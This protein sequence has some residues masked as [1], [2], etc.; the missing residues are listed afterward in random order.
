MEMCW[1][2]GFEDI[3]TIDPKMIGILDVARRVA[4]TTSN[5]LIIGESGTGKELVARGIHRLSPR[6]EEPFLAVNC[7][8]IPSE[9]LESELMGY[10]R[11]AFTGAFAR[12][13]GDFESANGGTIFL[14]EISNLPLPLQA[15]LLRILQEREIKR[16]GSNKTMK[17]DVRVVS[18]TNVDLETGVEK[19]SFRQDLYFRLNVIPIHLLPLR[20]RIK[21]IPIL[22]D[23]FLEKSCS[24]IKKNVQGYSREIIPILERHPWPGNVREF[25]NMIERIVVLTE[26]GKVITIKD[27]PTNII[28]SDS[29]DYSQVTEDGLGLRE[30]CLVYEKVEIVK[31]LHDTKW[32][33]GKAANLLKIHRNTLIQKM[34]KLHIPSGSKKIEKVKDNA[35]W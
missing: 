18:A 4:N 23:H 32:N 19:G 22:L 7:G 29:T 9:L 21:D 34:K 31:A 35:V 26:S 3:K 13:V 16:L 15:K 30:K 17:L 24:K 1:S 8:A 11:G 28:L 20:S 33:R 14:D 27:L 5:V 12:R 25:E 10:E 2:K 6:S